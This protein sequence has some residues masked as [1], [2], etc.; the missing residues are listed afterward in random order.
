MEEGICGM[1]AIDI[2]QT[3]QEKPANTITYTNVGNFKKLVISK[4]C[5]EHLSKIIYQK[6]TKQWIRG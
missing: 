4:K 6:V 1:Q 3:N 2:I 5:D